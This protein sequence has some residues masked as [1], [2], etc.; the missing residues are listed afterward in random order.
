MNQIARSRVY[1]ALA[2]GLV[3][4]GCALDAEDDAA[5]SAGP[6]P[7]TSQ[8]EEALS[9]LFGPPKHYQLVRAGEYR[10]HS[11]TASGS[12]RWYMP[13]VIEDQNGDGE[14]DLL[15]GQPYGVGAVPGRQG[16]VRILS[17]SDLS[18]LQVIS[19]GDIDDTYEGTFGYAA[20]SLGDINFDGKTDLAIGSPVIRGRNPDDGT[21]DPAGY[22]NNGITWLAK[23]RPGGGYDV[24]RI[25][26][27]DPM[28]F[29][30][31]WMAPISLELPRM[32]RHGPPRAW[33]ALH[34]PQLGLASAEAK[35]RAG[36][37]WGIEP[38]T[39]TV[40]YRGSDDPAN[41]DT[42]SERRGYF[43]AQT[44]DLDGNGVTDFLAT[45]NG[46]WLAG[47]PDPRVYPGRVYFHDGLTG[48]LIRAIEGVGPNQAL[49]YRSGGRQIDDVDGDGVEDFLIGS[50]LDAGVSGFANGGVVY[51]IS[52]RAIRSSSEKVLKIAEHPEIVLRT[53]AGLNA[54]ALF[55]DSM[56]NA[57]DL[58]GDGV[59]EYAI[60][61]MGTRGTSGASSTGAVFVYSGRTGAELQRIEGEAANLYLGQQ[62]ISDRANGT[63]YVVDVYFPDP[64]T[65][66]SIGRVLLYRA[67][68]APAG[69]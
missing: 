6:E 57:F 39:A 59:D 44:S 35:F 7:A 12:G 64:A 22:V 52:G 30:G 26:G 62:V 27:G 38:R 48:R 36:R 11:T 19:P 43:I 47:D 34:A 1:S 40:A 42:I 9:G 15:L 25:V 49:G 67:T 63:L 10:G 29:F 69:A 32:F 45:A 56:T 55:G 2:C 14:N 17:G 53:H 51:V 18:E 41:N 3:C 61:A 20:H 28:G 23:S 37:V 65:G 58:D 50:G 5:S 13:S 21:L 54:G 60:A 8:R 66:R 24:E 31:Y 33:R 46:Q 16:A 4:G 68:P